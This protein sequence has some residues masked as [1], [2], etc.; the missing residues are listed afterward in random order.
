ME[1][2]SRFEATICG[3]IES[4][5][6]LAAEAVLPRDAQKYSM[7]EFKTRLLDSVPPDV[8]MISSKE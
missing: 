2:C 3:R 4:P 1:S 5:V 8:K 7:A 6:R